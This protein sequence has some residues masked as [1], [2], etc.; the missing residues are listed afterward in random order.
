MLQEN[1]SKHF[2]KDGN[3]QR[4]VDE[5]TKSI[6]ALRIAMAIER[7][8][9][10]PAGLRVEQSIYPTSPRA[11]WSSITFNTLVIS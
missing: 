7:T 9:K 10:I 4:E 2:N 1:G 6:W 11:R 5:D 3:E 8:K